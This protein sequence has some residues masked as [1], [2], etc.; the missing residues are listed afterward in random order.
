MIDADAG[1]RVLAEAERRGFRLVG[2]QPSHEGRTFS[3]EDVATNE[4][5]QMSL[6]E[7]YTEFDMLGMLARADAALRGTV[8]HAA[9]PDA[10]MA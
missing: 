9:S 7:D 2:S 3:M 4:L 8:V 6:P 5:V 1:R 10:W